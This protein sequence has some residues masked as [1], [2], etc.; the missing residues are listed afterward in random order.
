[1]ADGRWQMAD[2][3]WQMADGRW[4]NDVL[5]FREVKAFPTLFLTSAN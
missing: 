1:M 3:R 4:Q 2:G 5:A